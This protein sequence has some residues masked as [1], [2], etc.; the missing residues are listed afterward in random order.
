MSEQK[1][2]WPGGQVGAVS[3]TYDDAL[4]V[5]FEAVGPLLAEK[6][7]T[8]TFNVCSYPSLTE[9]TGRWREVAAMGHELGNHS[10]FHPC[11]REPAERF[12]WLAPH[13]DLCEY[14]RQRWHDEL[15]VANCLLGLIDGRTARTYGNTCCN[16]TIG[17]G[18]QERD[19]GDLI[20]SLFVAG[21]G[22]LNK[23]IV[24]PATLDYP[25]LGH[26]S[27][28][29][30]TCAE[31]VPLVEQAEAVGGWIV[32]MF[33]GV[34]KGTHNGFIDTAEHAQFVDY[35][36][37][38]RQQIWTASMVDVASHLRQAGHAGVREF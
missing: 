35:L 10:L 13:Y 33:H 12:S 38:R 11:R 28:D 30:R 36:A 25:A 18:D 26:F 5:H 32:F 2:V 34:G 31:L 20:E 7:M 14:S 22:K 15:R 23:Q 8:A 37:A 17:R 3:L 16:T 27:G 1:F 6:G 21:R 19:F 24:T 9:N 4:P 29:G